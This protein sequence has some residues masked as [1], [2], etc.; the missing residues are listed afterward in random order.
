MSQQDAVQNPF[1]YTGIVRRESFCN[2]KNELRDLRR[3]M[4]DGESLFVYSERRLGKTSLV[5]L[6]LDGLPARRFVSAYVD[7]WPTD[8]ELGFARA[9][10][11]AL[12]EATSTTADKLLSTARGLFGRLAPVLTL[13][14][15]GKPQVS[16]GVDH[17]PDPDLQLDEV[18]A[19]PAAIARQQKRRVVLIYDEFQ[20]IATY[21]TDRVE[22]LLRSASQDAAEVSFL[23]LGSRR[24][25]I[26]RL[27]LDQNRPLYRS[28]GHYPLGP[29]AAKHWVPFIC[30]RFERSGKRIEPHQATAICDLTGGHPYYTQ[31]LCHVLWQ[32]YDTVDEAALEQAIEMLLGREGY[33]FSA[34]WEGLTQSAQRTLRGLASATGVVKP[35]S[36][37]FLRDHRL[38]SASTVQRALDQLVARDLVQRDEGS[39]MIVDRFFRI[40]VERL[41]RA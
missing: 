26:E 3:A 29:I 32:R 33:A 38:G 17:S 20:Q 41:A 7:L 37:R 10:A 4:E 36:A 24:H 13:D 39:W 18:L 6:A 30:Q 5:R 25:L 14:G 19:A 11:K 12:T 1:Q 23:F 15:E 31:H 9:T 21:G 22:R 27:L 35:F 2:R 16:F 40:W 34:L 8:D 28:A